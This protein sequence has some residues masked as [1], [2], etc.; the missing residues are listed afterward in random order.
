MSAAEWQEVIE[1]TAIGGLP[2]AML[3]TIAWALS[4]GWIRK[5]DVPPPSRSEACRFLGFMFVVIVVSFITIPMV[6]RGHSNTFPQEADTLGYF[7]CL[8]LASLMMVGF[9][10]ESYRR[11]PSQQAVFIVGVG[12]VAAVLTVAAFAVIGMAIAASAYT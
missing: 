10:V 4:G 5:K 2:T 12:L 7:A 11:Q 3:M 8:G 9:H 6:I 1:V